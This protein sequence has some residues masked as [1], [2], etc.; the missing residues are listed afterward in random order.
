MR[1]PT[2]GVEIGLHASGPTGYWV[3]PLHT[4]SLSETGL[5]K[6]HQGTVV[7]PWW[8]LHIAPGKEWSGVTTHDVRVLL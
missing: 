3:L 7:M 4:V 8:T 5:Q 6:T 2:Q 1:D